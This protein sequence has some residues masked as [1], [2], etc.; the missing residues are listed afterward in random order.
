MLSQ[1]ACELARDVGYLI[2]S[3]MYDIF[4]SSSPE[5]EQ[6][7]RSKRKKPRVHSR[8][9][10]G[11]VVHAGPRVVQVEWKLP[12]RLRKPV[13]QQLEKERAERRRRHDASVTFARKP[14]RTQNLLEADPDTRRPGNRVRKPKNFFNR[15]AE[16]NTA[17][18]Y[19]DGKPQLHVAAPP[20]MGRV[21]RAGAA[22]GRRVM[23]P[24]T[25][26]VRRHT[27]QVQPQGVAKKPQ[28]RKVIPRID[29]MAARRRA[30]RAGM[31]IAERDVPMRWNN[32]K[33]VQ[34][35]KELFAPVKKK[36]VT[37]AVTFS[38]WPGNWFKKEETVKEV[39][40]ESKK[41]LLIS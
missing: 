12:S 4:P 24:R 11:G 13:R 5:E 10:S 34:P 14:I 35:T 18:M 33:E 9:S 21:V 37:P 15:G 28:R 41:K 39:T 19:K 20:Y 26:E 3:Y 7:R 31:P 22:P 29:P 1:D 27:V 23:Q 16:Y 38:L 2:R 8:Q 32:A 17:D 30:A 6:L 36:K 25:E 40:Q